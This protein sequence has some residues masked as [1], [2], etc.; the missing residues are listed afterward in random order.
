MVGVAVA[1]VERV[2][3]VAHVV[4]VITAI[5]HPVDISTQSG[6]E[7]HVYTVVGSTVIEEHPQA[8]VMAA[9]ER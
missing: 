3:A 1:T 2:V 9:A 8:R 7:G 5:P 4:G 6:E